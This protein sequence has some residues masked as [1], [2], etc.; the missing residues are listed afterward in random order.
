MVYSEGDSN[1]NTVKIRQCFADI[2]QDF[3]GEVRYSWI[4]SSRSYW[5]VEMIGETGSRN[6][7]PQPMQ[8]K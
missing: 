1:L 6:K 2:H 3:S 4:D 8:E 7:G 5:Y